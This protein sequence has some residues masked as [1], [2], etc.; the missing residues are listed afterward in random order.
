M[1]PCFVVLLGGA[2]LTSTGRK[3]K[4]DM[5]GLA[6]TLLEQARS[7]PHVPLGCYVLCS[8]RP[9]AGFTAARR[10]H[11][12]SCH[13]TG[14]DSVGQ[15]R[16]PARGR[17][18]RPICQARPTLTCCARCRSTSCRAT[19]RAWRAPCGR[20]C[21]R[22]LLQTSLRSTPPTPTCRPWTRP[23]RTRRR[24]CVRCFRTWSTLSLAWARPRLG[25]PRSAR[26]PP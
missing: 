20:R 26:S 18:R 10:Q 15:R 5:D 7:V 2:L 19:W 25:S 23:S 9:W 11:R 4:G 21:R 16:T 24:T 13:H 14:V 6:D 17:A 1:S 12:Q 8:A 3:V 22:S